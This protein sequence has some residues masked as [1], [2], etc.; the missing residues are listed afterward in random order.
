M[1]SM[2]LLVFHNILFAQYKSIYFENLYND[3][4]EN[5]KGDLLII[6]TAWSEKARM[7]HFDK[8]TILKSIKYPFFLISKEKP[9]EEISS[10]R[11]FIQSIFYIF[12]F[13]PSIVNFTGYNSWSIFFLLIICKTLRIKTIIT[14]ESVIKNIFQASNIK[15]SINK[16]IKR[17]VLSQSDYF[18]TF[19]INANNLLF[20][21]NIPKSKILNFGNTFSKKLINS[22]HKRE[23]VIVSSKLKFLY[24]GRLSN[25]KNLFQSIHILSLINKKHPLEFDIFGDGILLNELSEYCKSNNFTFVSIKSPIKWEN[26]DKIYPSYNYLILLSKIEPWGMVA[27]E[28]LHFNVK[29]ICSSNCG[30]SNDLVIDQKNGLIIDI[31]NEE[32]SLEKLEK[33]LNLNI[34][35]NLFTSRNNLIF[36]ESYAIKKFIEKIYLIHDSK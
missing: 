10:L 5:K 2:R 3:I 32:Q 30:C 7:N 36:D 15:D 19:G 20:D 29:V 34:T 18:Y 28:A 12:S 11:I 33:Y 21:L 24:I 23:D 14:N 4:I 1:K 22:Y 35:S 25:E 27:N 26:I 6:Q 8:E 31:Y 13:K 17:F 9:L 16:L